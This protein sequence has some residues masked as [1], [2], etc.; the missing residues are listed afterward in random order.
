MV[1]DS[2]SMIRRIPAGLTFEQAAV[3]A[4][5]FPV[6]YKALVCQDAIKAGDT[7]LIH[8]AAGG[9]GVAAVQIAANMGCRVF[10]TASSREKC[11]YAEEF[12]AEVCLET[13]QENWCDRVMDLTAGRGVNFVFDPAGM[14]S[15]SLKCLAQGGQILVVGFVATQ[16]SMEKVSMGRALMKEATIRGYVS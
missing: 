16:D 11:D 13:S 3:L 9:L 1:V 15:S 6:A 14:V 2:G 4:G 7:V 5:T 10:G 8:T 12:G